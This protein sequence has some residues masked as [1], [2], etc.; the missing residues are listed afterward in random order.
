MAKVFV[1]LISAAMGFALACG[2]TSPAAKAPA[3]TWSLV[4]VV[5][6]KVVVDKGGITK[7][8][9][10]GIRHKGQRCFGAAKLAKAPKGK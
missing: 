10:L 7:S 2:S 9:C 8:A 1:P 4:H 5:K 6:G 3:G